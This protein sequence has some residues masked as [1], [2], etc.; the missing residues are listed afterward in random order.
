MTVD[1]IPRLRMFA[2]PNGSGKSTIKSL[3]APNLLGVYVNPDDIQKQIESTGS[4]DF[5][6]FGFPCDIN[7]LRKHFQNSPLAARAGLN[8]QLEQLRLNVQSLVIPAALSNSYLASI[9]AD[10]IR[11]QLLNRKISFTFETVMSS[12]DKIELLAKA[13]VQGFRTYLYYI[14]TDNPAINVWRVKRRVELGGHDVPTD[15]IISRFHR[16]LALLPDAIRNSDR[17]YL[18]DNSGTE[19]FWIAEI[20]SG[21]EVRIQSDQLP[22]WFKKS[23]WDNLQSS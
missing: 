15:K 6:E 23:V 9:L 20:T 21:N 4:L 17:A 8:L 1:A 10:F 3:L 22:D 14:A 13:K 2:G 19:Q 12:P 18:F 11:Q 7:E 16:S 5:A